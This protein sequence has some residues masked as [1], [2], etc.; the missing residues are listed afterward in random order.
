M[1][2]IT[3][4]LTTKVKFC[5]CA[6]AYQDEKYGKQNRVHNLKQKNKEVKSWRCTVCGKES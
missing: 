1:E 5:P 2:V 3:E 4:T 6:H